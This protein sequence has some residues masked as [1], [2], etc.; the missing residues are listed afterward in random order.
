MTPDRCASRTAL[1]VAALL[2]TV[3][4][5]LAA[6]RADGSADVGTDDRPIER[7]VVSERHP[8][9][10]A[11]APG[12]LSAYSGEA[13]RAAGVA[14]TLDLPALV[15]GLVLTTNSIFAQPY[16]RGVGSDLISA[17][18]DSAVAVFVDGVYQPRPAGALFQLVDVERV[19][20]AKGPRGTEWGR[21]A[22]GGAIHVLTRAP[23]RGFHVEGGA[24]GGSFGAFESS[25]V[26]NVPVAGDAFALRVAG[27]RGVSGGFAEN[28]FGPED[29]LDAVDYSVVRARLGTVGDG[30]VR[31]SLSG[32]Y[33]LDE[34]TRGLTPKLRRPFSGSP[35]VALG[36]TVP[37]DARRVLLDVHPEARLE[38][39]GGALRLEI[40]AGPVTVESLTAVRGE[41]M[42]EA[43][44]LDGTELPFLANF[45]R[46]R[47]VAWSQEL[48]ARGELGDRVE[49]LAGVFH[50]DEDA[51]QALDVR[52][53]NATRDEPM[54]HVDTRALG[55]FA[56]ARARVAGP[57]HL[58]AGVRYSDEERRIRYAE[59]LNG[60]PIARFERSSRWDEWTPRV[61]LELE[62]GDDALVYASAERG[63]KAGGY[64]TTVPQTSPFA[65]ETLWAYEVGARAAL[66][67]DR[68]HARA[69]AFYYDYDDIQLQVLAPPP[70]T[71]PFPLV[72]NAGKATIWG[73]ELD[74]QAELA[75]WL[76]VDSSVAYLDAT[77][78]RLVAPN[79]NDATASPIL[80]GQRMPK[81]PKLSLRA[82]AVAT[83]AAGPGEIEAL[84]EYRW[85]SAMFFDLFE[86]RLARQPAFDVW[87]ARLAF[88]TPD[89]GFE[90]AVFGRNLGDTLYA[91]SNVRLDGQLGNVF[92]WSPPRTFGAELALRY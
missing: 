29:D 48:V 32:D 44:D 40:D 51:F 70:S 49:W 34:S 55:V 37:G 62:L 2:V 31:V 46:E 71:I 60:A 79:P 26:V 57:L 20:V 69:A 3:L 74:S 82:A 87:N 10:L 35:A 91:Q 28:R 38:L 81:A 77:F 4:L 18:A 63:F 13:L 25:G 90:V 66:L 68:V 47:S 33:A 65:P 64:N 92:F 58:S 14:S 11:K 17:G 43:L 72:R 78:D 76:R 88:A 86:D 23:E 19:E 61:A 12:S 5:P 56:S 53:A 59:R 36:G 67:G 8:T 27:A 54:G 15:P 6:A 1:P 84:V 30:A 41:R 85:Q 83:C 45:P 21:N 16:V 24:R 89:G 9:E 39:Y 75:P 73:F 42:R 50:L 22:T 52:I 7:L 80:D